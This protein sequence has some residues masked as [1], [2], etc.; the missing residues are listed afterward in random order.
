MSSP[1]NPPL[2]SALL[3]LPSRFGEVRI[4]HPGEHRLVDRVPDFANPGQVSTEVRCRGEQYAAHCP[5]CGDDRRRLFISYEYGQPDPVTRRKNF[6]LWICHNEACHKD[7]TNRQVLRSMLQ[8]P[9]GRQRRLLHVATAASNTL[10]PRPITM[11]LPDGLLPL[12]ALSSAHPAVAYLTEE[13]GFAMSVLTTWQ[14][15]FC[16][17]SIN[18]R[19]SPANRIV[20]PIYKPAAM[21]ADAHTSELNLAIGGW[22]ARVV[23]GLDPVA[24]VDAKYLSAAGMATSELLYG[25]PEALEATGP[26]II[27]EGPT[28]VWRIGAGAVALL[29]K[30]LHRPK[31]LLL[32][33]YFADRPLVVMLDPEAM[34][35]AMEIQRELQLARGPHGSGPVVVAQLPAGGRDPAACT[36]EEIQSAVAAAL[37]RPVNFSTN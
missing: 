24:A 37:G 3:S 29:G 23:P 4:V 12:A 27:V 8:L 18:C 22:Q 1:L 25:L 7:P 35:E 30:V 21:F 19:P 26:I 28:D 6:S 10:P 32:T 20:I 17:F 36:P 13:R 9:L 11:Q 16:D 15:S 33:H 34:E 5:F 14:V 2:Y 31:V